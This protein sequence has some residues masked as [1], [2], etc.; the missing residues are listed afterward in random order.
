MFE[1]AWSEQAVEDLGRIWDAIPH[2][3]PHLRVARSVIEH[4]LRH[5]PIEQSE[6]RES[7]TMRVM[8]AYPLA[9][10]FHI[11]ELDHQIV[12]L[13]AWSYRLRA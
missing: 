7:E 10:S 3:H 5:A 1:V 13:T 8:F 4:H 2:L 6:S 12:V 9:V 11:D